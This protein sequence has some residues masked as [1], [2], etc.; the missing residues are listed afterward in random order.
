MVTIANS[1]NVYTSING[2][3]VI[4]PFIDQKKKKYGSILPAEMLFNKSI[5]F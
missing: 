1:R 2:I 5:V 3:K 4:F